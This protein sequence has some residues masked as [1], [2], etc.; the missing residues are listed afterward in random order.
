MQL[1][2]PSQIEE[3]EFMPELMLKRSPGEWV[4]DKQHCQQGSH[5]I[6]SCCIIVD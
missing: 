1:Q 5:K 3:K 6:D 4:M 2:V